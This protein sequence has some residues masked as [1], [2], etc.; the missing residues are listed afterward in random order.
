[1]DLGVVP[2]PSQVGQE[3]LDLLTAPSQ[4]SRER[5]HS[6]SLEGRAGIFIVPSTEL[7][8]LLVLGPAVGRPLESCLDNVDEAGFL[9]KI[10]ELGGP[11]KGTV[12][13]SGS[14]VQKSAPLVHSGVL[15]QSSVIATHDNVYVLQLNIATGGEVPCYVKNQ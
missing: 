10:L 2:V 14:L 3:D 15:S 8:E 12:K 13:L 5:G 6:Q 9:K 7:L 4:T 11:F 1:M